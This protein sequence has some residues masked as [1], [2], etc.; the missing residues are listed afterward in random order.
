MYM[1]RPLCVIFSLSLSPSPSTLLRNYFDLPDHIYKC[2]RDMI[3][4][5]DKHTN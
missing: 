3:S 1:Y 5:Q 4:P 2:N